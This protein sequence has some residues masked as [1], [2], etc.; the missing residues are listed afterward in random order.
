MVK[1]NN[2]NIGDNFPCYIT[3]EIGPTHKGLESAKKL[4]KHASDAGA[5]AVKF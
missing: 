4:I 2:K 1:I 5:D 3:F